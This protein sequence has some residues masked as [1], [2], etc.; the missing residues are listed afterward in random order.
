MNSA[1]GTAPGTTQRAATVASNVRFEDGVVCNAPGH[2][3]VSLSTSIL[4]GLVA[5]Y[6]LD[7]VS[8]ARAD[9]SGN[10]RDLSEASGFDPLIG[11][12]LVVGG[13]AGKIGGAALFPALTFHV[14]V[15]DQTSLEASLAY[16]GIS[17]LPLKTRDYVISDAALSLGFINPLKESRHDSSRVDVG[18]GSGVYFPAAVVLSSPL[19][20]VSLDVSLDSGDHNKVV[21]ET[22][23][24][25]DEVVLSVAFDSGEYQPIVVDEEAEPDLAE[26]NCSLESGSYTRT[27]FGAQEPLDQMTLTTSL[28]SG[29]YG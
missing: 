28:A 4:A 25:Q 29:S 27:V 9:A 24:E 19:D 22:P 21:F 15:N 13:E 26:I 1:G 7:E 20:Q 18:L 16:G 11:E 3:R 14:V 5:Q 23:S 8:G 17:P 2:E 6:R 12:S 10:G